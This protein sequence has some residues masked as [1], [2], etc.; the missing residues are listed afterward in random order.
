MAAAIVVLSIAV[1]W[2]IPSAPKHLTPGA[3]TG[4]P[5]A[6]AETKIPVPPPQQIAPPIAPSAATPTNVY[7]GRDQGFGRKVNSIFTTR[8]KEV[9]Y[10]ALIRYEPVDVP[11][12]EVPGIKEILQFYGRQGREL[13]RTLKRIDQEMEMTTDN[14][15]VP[16]RFITSIKMFLNPDGGR[17]VAYDMAQTTGGQP[18]RMLGHVSKNG[19]AI[20]VYRGGT[21]ADKQ[22]VTFVRDTFIPVEFSFVHQWYEAP[23]NRDALRKRE[24][25]KF[26]IF[27]PEAM[28]QVLLL[29]RP[30]DDQVIAVNDA[31]YDCAHYE[32]MT[33]ST[34]SAEGLFARQEMWFDKA[35]RVMMRRQ[36]FDASM[37]NADA[38]VTELEP[39]SRVE[40]LGRL[41][42]LPVLAPD[43]PFRAADYLLDRD[44][45]YKVTAREQDIGEVRVQFSKFQNGGKEP[46]FMPEKLD[47]KP[48]Y[49]STS[50]VRVDTGGSLRNEIAVTLYD[51]KW[52]P[53][54][55]ETHGEENTG[56]KL[57]YHVAAQIGNEKIR[58]ATHRDAL[59]EL[60]ASAAYQG[61]VAGA[62][63]GIQYK[64]GD[65]ESAWR[66]PLKRVPVSDDDAKSQESESAPR[67]LD[68]SWVRPLP[69][70]VFIS[71]FNRVEHLALLAARLPLPPLPEKET[72]PVKLAYQKAAMYLVRQNRCGVL[73]FETRPEPKPKLTERQKKRRTDDELKEPQLYV[74]NVTAAMMPCRFLMTSDGRILELN[75]KY[76][77][78]DV[79]YTLD[80]PIMQHREE[81]AKKK[82]LQEGPRLVR[83]PWW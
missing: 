57:N 43:V 12:E 60:K 78:G 46:P 77:S 14:L 58:V 47:A 34:Q 29:V 40:Q 22:E 45:N 17:V 4:G 33:V 20:E 11:S 67:I 70:N 56:V 73:L 6:P 50:H 23:E 38:P 76:G 35:T 31:T 3:N 16:L 79:T 68:Q 49:F 51:D 39:Y 66:D 55:Y 19:M 25:V 64:N 53:I 41:S 42:P 32:V 74:A 75:M 1:W 65:D 63:T 82:Q 83:P 2:S 21:L 18:Q 27:V 81:A 72:D 44:F 10:Q 28:A 8:K 13:P 62:E 71:D 24:Q 52:Q 80:D 61:A 15:G 54:H 7:I 26:S 30:M 37:A 59:Q 36:D 5:V 69:E 48:T 9:L